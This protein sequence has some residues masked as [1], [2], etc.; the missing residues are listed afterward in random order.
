M[1]KLQRSVG[2][3]ITVYCYNCSILLSVI[4]VNLLLCLMYK[5]CHK[6]VCIETI[7]YTGFCTVCNFR[8]PLGALEPIPCG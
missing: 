3:F 6:D 4:V 5:L 1:L 8:R 2:T 7:L